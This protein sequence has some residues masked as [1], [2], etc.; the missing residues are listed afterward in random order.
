MR[1]PR[2]SS[3]R[4][5]IILVVAITVAALAAA[6]AGAHIDADPSRVEP[7]ASTTVAF[8]V[9]H[10]C[11][12]SPTVKLKFKI[13]KD[14]Q[15]VEPEAKDGWATRSTRKT[16]VFKGGPLESDTED[17][18]A[19]SF[20]A[21]DTTT[22]LMWKVIQKCEEGAIRWIDTSDGAEEPPPVVGVGTDAPDGH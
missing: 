10:G 20:T 13:P 1:P 3:Q 6:P 8:V 15:D 2:R 9:E 4:I 7:G 12:E 18:F 22:V 17:R 16:V 5:V 21:P 19:I 14:I 11:D